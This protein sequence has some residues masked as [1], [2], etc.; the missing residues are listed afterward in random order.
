MF[1]RL[2][3]L[4]IDIPHMKHFIQSALDLDTKLIV[5]RTIIE[6][7]E[8]RKLIVVWVSHDS[9]WNHVDQQIMVDAEVDEAVRI[10]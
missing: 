1:G 4:F 7:V 9:S 5:E 6:E 3:Y 10:T 2:A 8:K